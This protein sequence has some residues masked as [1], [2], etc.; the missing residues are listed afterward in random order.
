MVRLCTER[1]MRWFGR[2]VLGFVLVD[3]SL[4]STTTGATRRGGV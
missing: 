1:L 4:A 3:R 2:L